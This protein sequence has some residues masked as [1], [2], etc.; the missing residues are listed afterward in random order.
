MVSSMIGWFFLG[1][2]V[3][4]LLAAVGDRRRAAGAQ[5]PA[6][7]AWL[8][9]AIIFGLVGAALQLARWTKRARILGAASR[10]QLGRALNLYEHGACR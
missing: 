4:F 7:R 10:N 3:I 9:I 8:R 1:L 5:S 6:R 2:A